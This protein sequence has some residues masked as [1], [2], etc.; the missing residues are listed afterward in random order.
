MIGG[1]ETHSRSE[2][3]NMNCNWTK[4]ATRTGVFCGLCRLSLF[5]LRKPDGHPFQFLTSPPPRQSTVGESCF[6]SA[7]IY[8][9]NT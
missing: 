7:A 6:A 9:A 8:T 4:A 2:I 3:A 5:P 1:V